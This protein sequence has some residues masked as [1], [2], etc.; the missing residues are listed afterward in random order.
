[1]SGLELKLRGEHTEQAEENEEPAYES[2]HDGPR[3]NPKIMGADNGKAG[4]KQDRTIEIN[5]GGCIPS[6]DVNID[7]F[8]YSDCNQRGADQS[9]DL[10]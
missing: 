5:A 1:M 9:C 4:D 8:G 10:F 6:S 3:A 7:R 2:D